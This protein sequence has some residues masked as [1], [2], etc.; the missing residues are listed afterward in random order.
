VEKLSVG[1]VVFVNFPFSDLIKSKLRPAVVIADGYIVNK[2]VGVLRTELHGL[3]TER[4]I[5]LINPVAFLNNE[6]FGNCRY[7]WSPPS[8]C[9]AF[10]NIANTF[11]S[12]F[13]CGENIKALRCNCDREQA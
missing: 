12:A 4:I 7:R 3:I 1:D 8:R 10:S 5:Q 6:I 2:K 13:A 11:R 9:R